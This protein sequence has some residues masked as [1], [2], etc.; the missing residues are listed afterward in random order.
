MTNQAMGEYLCVGDQIGLYSVETEGY[1]YSVQSRYLTLFKN[2]FPEINT[3]I[4]CA[5]WGGCDS[6][7]QFNF[8][9]FLEPD[10]QRHFLWSFYVEWFEME[11]V[12]RFVD[13]DEIVDC[14]SFL[15]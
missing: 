8:A 6:I 15:S 1:T 2:A 5:R 14:L 7:K 13:I 4:Y 9:A 3:N 12:V 10:S 11:V